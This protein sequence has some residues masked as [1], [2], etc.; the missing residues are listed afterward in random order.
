MNMAQSFDVGLVASLRI[1]RSGARCLALLF[2][3]SSG[4]VGPGIGAAEAQTAG[5]TY[6]VSSI[7]IEG[8]RRIDTDAIQS[9]VKGRSGRVTSEQI[10][11][12]IKTPDFLTRLM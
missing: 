8:N 6:A 9:L 1:V 3:L 2:L 4:F 12:D 11:Q 7:V 10:S 5:D